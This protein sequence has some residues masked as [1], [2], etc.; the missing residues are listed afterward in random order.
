MVGVIDYK[1]FRIIAISL[2]P[3]KGS[4]LVYGSNDGGRTFNS[5]DP[6]VNE[7]MFKLGETL[8]LQAHRVADGTE[9]RTAA[10]VGKRLKKKPRIDFR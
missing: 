6:V 4:T 2:L 1:G 10:D 5:T 7:D 8:N 3:I 9:I